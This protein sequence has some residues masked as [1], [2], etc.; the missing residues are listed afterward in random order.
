MK[1]VLRPCRGAVIDS[2]QAML[3]EE[4]RVPDKADPEKMETRGEERGQHRQR[5]S[6][7]PGLVCPLRSASQR[8]REGSRYLLANPSDTALLIVIK[9]ERSRTRTQ[10]HTHAR[11]RMHTWSHSHVHTHGPGCACSAHAQSKPRANS[12]FL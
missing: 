5:P 1:V 8:E 11:V 9:H 6:G 12:H 2:K 3:M 7:R 10:T 4:A